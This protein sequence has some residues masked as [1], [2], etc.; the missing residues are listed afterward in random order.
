MK[1]LVTTD[2]IGGVWTYSL[3]LVRALEKEGVRTA[4]ATMGYCLSRAQREELRRI[5]TVKVYE[6]CFRLEWMDDPWDDVEQAGRWLLDVED[7]FEPDV[8]HLNGY[9]HAAL[10]WSAPVLVVG[11]SCVLSW[12]QAVK[13]APAPASWSRYG[14]EV[15][16]GLHAAHRVIAPTRA[17]LE[18][19][20]QL[21]G[22]LPGP[23]VISNARDPDLFAPKAKEPFI[24]AAGRLWDEAKNI[25]ILDQVA[26]HLPWPIYVAGDAQHP[27]G[28]RR[29]PQHIRPVGS[30][31][32]SQIGDWFG[33]AAIY[34]LPARYE[35]FGLSIL[36]AAL[37]GCALV[38]GDIPS[39]R[40]VWGDAAMY[41]D[42]DDPS[43]L[44]QLLRTLIRDDVCR[45]VYADRAAVRAREYH[46]KRMAGEYLAVYQDLAARMP[47]REA[48]LV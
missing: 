16:R 41:V 2:N 47:A 25:M 11:H 30:F 36:E 9:A 28:T 13:K 23:G 48:H 10:P 40:E 37:S 21:Y 19:L 29:D 4:L 42:P 20:D 38:L 32:P 43:A 35:P 22:P 15:R 14:R 27:S 3:E 18:C 6:S 24:F 39:L 1:V 26:P 5:E 8:I 31:S 33:R 12:W 17:M 46:P 45:A 44:R 7:D 34:A